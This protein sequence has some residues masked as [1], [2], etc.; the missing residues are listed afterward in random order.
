MRKTKNK[1]SG[2]IWWI[3][4]FFV[5]AALIVVLLLHFLDESDKSFIVISGVIG[6]YVSLFSLVLMFA[7]FK[8][9]RDIS[10]ETKDKMDSVISIS[11]L[12]KHAELARSAQSDVNQ[13]KDDLAIY[14][15]QIIK[16]TLIKLERRDDSDS[17]VISEYCGKL[18]TH[19]T[20]LRSHNTRI[21]RQVING[22]L[23]DIAD[24]LL[25]QEECIK[26]KSN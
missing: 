1:S 17:A 26:E 22:D 13:E 6:G 2:Q 10:S 20:S 3:V 21:R 4:S 18:G 14:K 9:I 11:N 19:L 23:E 24:F 16:E 15:I 25:R 7:Q 8:S 12:A 5:L